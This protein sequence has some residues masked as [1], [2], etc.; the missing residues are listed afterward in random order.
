M[1]RRSLNSQIGQSFELTFSV[2]NDGVGGRTWMVVDDVAVTVCL[3]GCRLQRR[4]TLPGPTGTPCRPT[5]VP[6]PIPP[7]CMDILTNGDFEWDGAWNLGGTPLVPFYAGPPNPVLSGNRSMALGAVLSSTPSNVASY[8]SIQ[9]AVT[10]PAT[11]QT[12]QI[13][14]WYFPSSTAAAGGLN[15]QELVLLD[16]LNYEETI[17]VP[18]RV[19]AERQRMDCTAEID[20][21]RYPGANGDGLLQR[22]Q[23]RRR[24]AHQH[25][26]GPGAGAG[27][28]CR[29]HHACL[30]QHPANIRKRYRAQVTPLPTVQVA[31]PAVAANNQQTVIAVGAGPT[32]LP[33]VTP[34]TPAPS[35]TETPR[36][37]QGSR[38]NLDQLNS[39]WLIILV[40]SGIVLLAVVLALL[41][42]RGDKEETRPGS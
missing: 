13:R 2:Y 11:A 41:F 22:P 9:Q 6:S 30:R 14:F 25:V 42:F 17:E 31:P 29:G 8:S 3:P 28:R 33:A 32:P 16:P 10:I 12:A 38:L 15:R 26:P 4:T 7:N 39:P 37:E 19:T 20:L 24:H 18:W 21:T 5:A 34:G 1:I 35:A 27:L 36:R 40:I 23:R